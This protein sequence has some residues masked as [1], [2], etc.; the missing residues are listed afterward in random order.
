MQVMSCNL[1]V[2]EQYASPNVMSKKYGKN[3]SGPILDFE[4]WQ[5]QVHEMIKS[6][7]LWKFNVYP[8]TLYVYDLAWNDCD[9]LL[10]D[11]RGKEIARQLIRSVGSISANIDEGY[12]RGYGKDYA[13]RLRIAIGE[14]REARSWY[15][16]ARKLLPPE[17]VDLRIQQLS[18]NHRHDRSKHHQ[19]TSV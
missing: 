16:K 11:V 7:P 5:M 13:F 9:N 8:K 17:I 18:E 4:S 14:A 10:N 6:D 3:M 19:T 15:W 2:S 12:G 1:K